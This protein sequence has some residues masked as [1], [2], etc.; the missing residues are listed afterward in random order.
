MMKV[1]TPGRI[2]LFGEH[3]D[4]LL[5]PVIA[6]AISQ[7]IT[8]TGSKRMGGI[9]S[10]EMPDIGVTTTLKLSVIQQQEILDLY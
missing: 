5:L 7:R 6:C 4:Y 2:C 10:I 1:S 9:I 8:I 3:Q